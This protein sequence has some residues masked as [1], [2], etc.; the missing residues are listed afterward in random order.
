MKNITA[1]ILCWLIAVNTFAQK[2][3]SQW[4]Y[5]DASGKL[6][7]KT[8]PTGDK[9][10]DFSHAGYRGGG[11]ALP[12][13]PAKR[14]I[15]PSGVDDD[16][17]I[18]QEAINQVAAM[19]LNNGFRGAVELS[20]GVFTCSGPIILSVPG[21]V[22]RGAGSGKTTIKMIG[23]PHT[24]IVIGRG[25]KDVPLGKTERLDNDLAN[26][27]QIL[28]TDTYVPSGAMTFTVADASAFS[29]GDT[30][31]IKRPITE[32]WVHF[33]GMDNMVREGKPQTWI[34]T[35]ARGISKKI[36]TGIVNNKLTVDVPLADSYDSRFLNPPGT[37]VAKVK[38]VSRVTQVGVENIHIQCPPLEID[39][40]HAPYAGIR[41]GGD[42]CW[43]KNVFCEETM[44]TTVLAGNRITME[45][46]I[47]KHTYPNLGASKPTDFSLEG[48][49]NLID[50]CEITGGNTYFVWTSSLIPG[51]NVLLNCTFKGIG[52]RIQPHQRWATGLLVDNCTVPDGGIDFMNRGVAGSG[53][54]WT[55]G[56]AV[57]WN[58][59]AK[60]YIIQNPPGA[61]NWAIGCIGKRE[62]TARLFDSSPVLAEGNFDSHGVPVAIQSL[63]LAQLADRL[64]QTA[65]KN[66]GYA[67]NTVRM[68]PNKHIDASPVKTNYDKTFGLNRALNRPVNTSSVKGNS[69]EFGGE[70]AI[71]G[72]KGTYWC[73]GD[74]VTKATIEI[75]MEGP[76]NINT[77][78][79]SEALGP[80]IK[81]YKFEALVNSDWKLLAGGSGVVAKKQILKFPANKAWKVK[82][83][84]QKANG[85]I[86]VNNLGLFLR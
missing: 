16:T 34:K 33:M 68:F 6:A 73:A 19:P 23:A 21:V 15:K 53:H 83:T 17:P 49:E 70:K 57:A 82:L 54:G 40:G 72:D 59:V 10:M 35:G 81:A 36:I 78:Q 42:D 66:I 61:I 25:N 11:V 22:L 13:V 58:C 3:T 28:V 27:A 65:I 64:G 62:Q 20:P 75:D 18:I 1:F 7:Y 2:G 4:V 48:S 47:V 39:Y 74:S 69:R 29:I 77:I 31:A 80:H 38:P 44:N 55:M 9:I 84:I 56:W 41:V 45:K 63:Y 30:I 26:T 85:P 52:S 8:T 37:E 71:D 24:A 86:A 51:P 46:V 79:F 12:V 60:T 50:R 5:R 76:V 67:A 14:F 32:S 43:V